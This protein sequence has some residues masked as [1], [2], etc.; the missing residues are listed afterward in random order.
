MNEHWKLARPTYIENW[1]PALRALSVRSEG[2]GL[3]TTE[4]ATLGRMN[5]EWGEAF[6]AY[7]PTQYPWEDELTIE[8]LT[9]RVDELV[10]RFPNGAFVRLGSRSPKDSWWGH[11][12]GFQCFEGMT[13]MRLLLDS[14]E[15]VHDDLSMALHYTYNPWIWVR[16][17]R[18]IPHW[19]EFRCFM[20]DR[21]L[22]GVSQYFYRELWC[23]GDA[24]VSPRELL[25]DLTETFW[26]R[27]QRIC[28][29]D[30]VVFDI[31]TDNPGAWTLI[32]I[33]PFFDL[34]DPC[35]YSWADGGDFDGGIRVNKGAKG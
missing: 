18:D 7:H 8:R 34:T 9:G 23:P 1:S 33:N 35:L 14:S 11:E 32:E 24:L 20:R 28:P 21:K 30:D 29:L 25:A 4:A 2:F 6:V 17:W 31:T 19:A 12:H 27:F 5:G 15:R 13:A 22:V 10:R 26:P 16:E 3:L